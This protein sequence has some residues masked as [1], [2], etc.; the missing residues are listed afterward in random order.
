M[1]DISV[2]TFTAKLQNK[3]LTKNRV[4]ADEMTVRHADKIVGK[5]GKLQPIFDSNIVRQDSHY[6][7][8]L[9]RLSVIGN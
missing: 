3:K 2:V 9:A 4:D 7:R 6:P 8:W 5:L 1:T